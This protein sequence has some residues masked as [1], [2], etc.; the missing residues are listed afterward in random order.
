MNLVLFIHLLIMIHLFNSLIIQNHNPL[1]LCLVMNFIT[2][3][4]QF[5]L[6]F[7]LVYHLQVPSYNHQHHFYLVSHWSVSLL[8]MIWNHHHF[9][10]CL[11]YYIEYF[12]QAHLFFLYCPTSNLKMIKRKI[13]LIIN[14]KVNYLMTS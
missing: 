7:N 13:I 4:D 2:F 12:Q 5:H 1:F 9:I 3:I 10:P 6:I 14:I 11:E 8:I